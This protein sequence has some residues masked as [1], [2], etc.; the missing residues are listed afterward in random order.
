LTSLVG[1]FHFAEG[2]SRGRAVLLGLPLGLLAGTK[3]T[4]LMFVPPALAIVAFRLWE[5][6]EVRTDSAPIWRLLALALVTALSVGGYTYLRNWVTAGSPLFPATI[7]VFGMTLFP[8]WRSLD[9]SMMEKSPEFAIAPLRFLTSRPD[10]WGPHFVFLLLPAVLIAPLVA[11]LL[12]KGRKWSEVL[13]LATPVFLYIVFLRLVPDH[14]EIRY[15]FAAPALGALC[16]AWIV[17]RGLSPRFRAAAPALLGLSIAL[18]AVRFYALVKSP[19]EVNGKSYLAGRLAESA[20]AEFIEKAGVGKP[21]RVAIL[22]TNQPYLF[23]GNQL[24]NRVSYVPIHDGAGAEFYSWRSPLDFPHRS[25]DPSRKGRGE[26]FWKNL[27]ER[28]I[29]GIVIARTGTEYPAAAW[30]SNDPYR[31]KR[32]F[33]QEGHEIYVLDPTA[34]KTPDAHGFVTIDEGLP[35]SVDSPTDGAVVNGDLVIRGWC[36]ER[37]GGRVDPTEV[38]IDGERLEWTKLTRSPREDVSRALPEMGDTSQAGYEI[39]IPAARLA[40]GTHKLVVAF[41]TPG[42][43]VRYYPAVTI[44]VPERSAH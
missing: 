24:Q 10:L 40:P 16:L 15:I 44:Q 18:L 12:G 42:L 19:T 43:R 6:R 4:G 21:L 25:L 1:A 31:F 30:V 35:A 26:I 8:G 22:G 3:Y 36:V 34:A 13:V 20:A 14:R 39:T 17:D 9:R 38:R 41:T 28:E 11:I 23:M 5:T 37:G 2:P 27:L 32:V 7:K 33:A 29:Q